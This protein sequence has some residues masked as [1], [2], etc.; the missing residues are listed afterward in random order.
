MKQKLHVGSDPSMGSSPAEPKHPGNPIL[1]GIGLTD[2]HAVVIDDRVYLF[3]T[4]DHSPDNQAFVMKDWWIWSSDDL[5]H[6][7][8]DC[9]LSPEDT[10]LARPFNDCWATFG[11][12]RNGRYYWYLSLGPRNIGVVVADSPAGP[13]LDPLGK[14]LIAE[15]LTPT[16]QRDPDIFIDDDGEAYMV[17][18]TFRYFLVRLG[19]DMISLAEAPREIE[20]INPCGPYGEGKTD[21]KPSIHKYRGL[22]YLSWSGFYAVSENLYGP[23]RFRGSMIDPAR[24]APEFFTQHLTHDRHGNFFE[25]H[26]QWYYITNDKSQP[27]RGEF[28]RD[29]IITYVHYHDNGDMAPVRIDA[30][31]VG[32]YDARKPIDAAD[33]FKAVKAEKRDCPAGGFDVRGLKEGSAL[34]YPNIRHLDHRTELT[35]S[36]VCGHPDGCV[37]DIH[38]D[39]P[40][41]PLLGSIALS[42]TGGGWWKFMP[43]H[44][45]L[46]LQA[47]TNGICL[48]FRGNPNEF[49]RLNRLHL[50]TNTSHP[51]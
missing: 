46:D 39:S 5:V 20:I 2:P 28:F 33:Y 13:W 18:G 43:F 25:F 12:R 14:P 38:G 29:S 4:H 35:L 51:E 36:V 6:W 8:Q 48:C 27:G 21:D 45:S 50:G 32:Q 15:G 34:Y 37:I 16:S 41:G 22:Y 26:N 24:V 3:A 17:Y 11:V 44:C 23:Y 30:M 10:H 42:P 47:S 19:A 9:V 40:E 49:C 1:P 7:R 31:G